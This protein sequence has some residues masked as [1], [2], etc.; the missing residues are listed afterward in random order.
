ML[1]GLLVRDRGLAGACSA[2]QVSGSWLP[3]VTAGSGAAGA[4]WLPAVRVLAAIWSLHGQGNGV[5]DRTR[6]I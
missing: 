3:G 1:A 4:C 6:G 5:P 2:G